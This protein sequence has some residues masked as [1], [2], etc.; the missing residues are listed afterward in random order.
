VSNNWVNTSK[1]AMLLLAVG[2]SACSSHKKQSDTEILVDDS[3]VSSDGLTLQDLE[4]DLPAEESLFMSETSSSLDSASIKAEIAN[5]NPSV[6][7]S[8]ASTKPSRPAAMPKVANQP[9]EKDGFLM[10]AFYFVQSDQESYSTL[11]QLFYGRPERA[12]MIASWN[13][14][15]PVK[16]GTLI[17]YNSHFRYQDSQRMLP[18][19]ED[20]GFQWNSYTV[21]KGDSLGSIAK[22]LYNDADTW[23]NLAAYNPELSSPDALSPG[24]IIR[25][26]KLDIDTESKRMASQPAA[27]NNSESVPS[28]KQLKQEVEQAV[29]IPQETLDEAANVQ[30]IQNG[31]LDQAEEFETNE[32]MANAPPPEAETLDKESALTNEEKG[33]ANI[34]DGLA[35]RSGEGLLKQKKLLYVG[36][37]LVI[38]S[39]LLIIVRRRS[40]KTKG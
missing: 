33:L 10:N 39:L 24:M 36:L 15:T 13:G 9:F 18:F 22:S 11:S 4:G 37:G 7:Y 12:R 25:T 40:A 5:S 32:Q 2:V 16:A 3:L 14:S 35:G 23:K 1:I 28:Q 17:Y 19:Y 31:R 38:L 29:S 20:Y 21:Q 26:P 34:E 6:E 27:R 8:E 30:A